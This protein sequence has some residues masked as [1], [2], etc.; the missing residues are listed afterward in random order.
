M[1]DILLDN[2]IVIDTNKKHNIS[3]AEIHGG[4]SFAHIRNFTGFSAQNTH[5]HMHQYTKYNC[6]RTEKQNENNLYI[7][8]SKI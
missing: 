3:I 8:P 4:S 7:L 1:C 2:K 6:H 5:T